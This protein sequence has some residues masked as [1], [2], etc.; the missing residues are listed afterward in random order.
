MGWRKG[1]RKDQEGDS[2]TRGKA[3][4][5]R[6]PE[7]AGDGGAISYLAAEVEVDGDLTTQG[8]LRIDGR[9]AGAVR[10]AASVL[11]GP[12]GVIDGDLNSCDAVIAGQVTG[13]VTVENRAELQGTARVEGELRAHLLKLDEGATLNGSV[14]MGQGDSTRQE[15][16]PEREDRGEEAGADASS[17]RGRKD[18]S[19][20]P[21]AEDGEE[22]EAA[23]SPAAAGGTP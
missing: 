10:A 14:I 22:D 7:T 19:P 23:P 1:G 3:A 21:S 13:C 17:S 20:K 18:G 4:E 15:G 12:D 11:V 6:A 16:P 9:I 8:S 2:G 5:A